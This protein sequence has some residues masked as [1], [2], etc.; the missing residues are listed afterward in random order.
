MSPVKLSLFNTGDDREQ[1]SVE[2]DDAL[3]AKL[4]QVVDAHPDLTMQ[5]ALRQGIQHIVTHG[6][7]KP[8]LT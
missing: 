7:S 5:E 4:R 3:V 2:L 1:E 6:P 8:D